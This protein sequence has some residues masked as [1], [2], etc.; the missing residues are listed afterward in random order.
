MSS[1]GAKL[2]SSGE[3]AALHHEVLAAARAALASAD[4][5]LTR[6][7][8]AVQLMVP[9]VSDCCIIDL[10]VAD[11]LRRVAVAAADPDTARLIFE[12][13]RRYVFKPEAAEGTARALRTGEA[14]LY[15]HVTDKLLRRAAR[16]DAHY[17]ML[18]TLN[19]CSSLVAPIVTGGRALG[20]VSL[21]AS[22]SGRHYGHADLAFV[23]AFTALVGATA[24]EVVNAG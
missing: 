14:V 13:S 22:S 16:D 4:P 6:L 3:P 2:P 23:R 12:L 9:S 20:A 21:F 10:L 11:E 8:G 5:A 1:A 24:E 18:R 17:R 7:Q 15:T 19:L